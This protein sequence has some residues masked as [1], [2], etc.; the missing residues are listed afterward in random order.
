[1]KRVQP[2]LL[3]AAGLLAGVTASSTG[4][5][6]HHSY[7]QM[8][9]DETVILRVSGVLTKLIWANPHVMLKVDGPEP[10]RIDLWSIELPARDTLTRLG[11]NRPS[12]GDEVVV[13]INPHLDANVRWDGDGSLPGFYVGVIFG[14]GSRFG[15]TSWSLEDVG[16]HGRAR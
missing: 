8:H 9:A 4:A 5:L 13:F 14:D 2:F 10:G 16:H 15:E 6:A 3:Q 7:R 11:M 12:I 1:M